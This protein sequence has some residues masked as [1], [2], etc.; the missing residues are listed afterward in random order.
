MGIG[1]DFS[2]MESRE[3]YLADAGAA[4]TLVAITEPREAVTKRH[5]STS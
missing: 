5:V 3:E 2:D 1:H 4:L